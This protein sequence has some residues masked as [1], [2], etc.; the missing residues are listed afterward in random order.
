VLEGEEEANGFHK[1]HGLRGEL[2]EVV[3][4]QRVSPD[5]GGT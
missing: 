3:G 4:A 5:L 1:P 2:G